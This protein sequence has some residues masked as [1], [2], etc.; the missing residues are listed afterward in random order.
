MAQTGTVALVSDKNFE[1]NDASLNLTMAN[2]VFLMEPQWNPMLEEQALD[3]VYRIG[4]T[5]EVK[6]VRYIV[7]GTLEEVSQPTCQL[8]IAFL[9]RSVLIREFSV[10]NRTNESLQSKLLTFL[11]DQQNG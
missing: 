1:S 8:K 11:D 3:R 9:L 6:T 5:K 7:S 4:Q 2:N 10:S